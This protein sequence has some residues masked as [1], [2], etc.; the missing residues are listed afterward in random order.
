MAKDSVRLH[1]TSIPILQIVNLMDRTNPLAHLRPINPNKPTTTPALRLHLLH[2]ISVRPIHEKHEYESLT[3]SLLQTAASP[4]PPTPPPCTS[5]PARR[6]APSATTARRRRRR[7]STPARS[8]TG[9]R[10]GTTA[11][12]PSSSTCITDSSRAEAV[13][14]R[15]GTVARVSR[16]IR[17]L[18][19]VITRIGVG[20]IMRRMESVRDCSRR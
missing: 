12:P 5:I 16:P 13:S 1:P 6:T 8:H 19:M 15:D 18:I 4:T 3:E 17:R 20:E 7:V 2:T 11:G 14:L 10:R 9:R